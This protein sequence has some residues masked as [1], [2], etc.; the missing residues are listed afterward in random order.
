M[1]E[2]ECSDAKCH[3]AKHHYT[4]SPGAVANVDFLSQLQF[5]FLSFEKLSTQTFF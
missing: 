1:L 2:T 5:F 4:D 3:S